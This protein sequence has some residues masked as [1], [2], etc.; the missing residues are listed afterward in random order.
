MCVAVK[1]DAYG[2]GAVAC[3]KAA[4]SC[5]VDFLAVAT[6]D[7]GIELRRAGIKTPILMLSICS[8][9][10]IPSAVRHSITPLV[11]DKEYIALFDKAASQRLL[12]KKFPV[13]LAVDT[14]MG[15]IG[16][17]P[18]EAAEIAKYIDS[19]K[20]LKLGGM[21]THFAVSDSTTKEN[22][23]Y[24]KQQFT[25]FK[26]AID[27][28]RN[29]GID[30]GICHCANSAATLDLPDMHLDMVRPGIIVYGYYPDMINKTYLEKK[31]TPIN[32][33]PVMTLETEVSAIRSF[34]KGKSIGYG[35]TW[36][37]TKSTEIAVLPIG[38][39]DAFFRRFSTA[40]VKIA[41]NGKP[42]PVR[43]RI[44]MDQ[45]MVDIGQQ[46]DVKR[47]DKAVIFGAAE[48][49]A[50]QTA[51]DIANLTDTISYEITSAVTKR[52]PREYVD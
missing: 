14:G 8:P 2:H 48:D 47:W 17:Q 9:E 30:P 52:V 28:V 35:R 11:F 49:G 38:Y 3:A 20:S 15:R 19:S 1:A 29:E 45:C 13:H 39:A 21:Q 27:S 6:V 51:G 34:A 7:E 31:G 10:E 16:C 46:N 32:L 50:L 37:A 5:G 25:L 42:Y 4:V 40:K 22:R 41:I 44:C 43:G 12:P 24:T 23:A 36:T 33:K 26:K 18:E